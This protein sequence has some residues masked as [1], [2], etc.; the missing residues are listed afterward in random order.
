MD[1]GLGGLQGFVMDREAWHAVVHGVTESDTTE[2]LNWTDTKLKKPAE[3]SPFLWC[4]ATDKTNQRKTMV[5]YGGSE[6]WLE[7]DK[8]ESGVIEM[9]RIL[10]GVLVLWLQT[11]TKIHSVIQI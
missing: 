6:D 2:R 1:M 3:K 8:Q 11:S 10:I 9:V 5:A 7:K 4:L